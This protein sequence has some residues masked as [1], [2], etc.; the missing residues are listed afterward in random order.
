MS[1]HIRGNA[2]KLKRFEDNTF[3]MSLLFGYMYHL[4]T[5]EEG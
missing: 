2:L 4:F 5:F 1:R 3:D